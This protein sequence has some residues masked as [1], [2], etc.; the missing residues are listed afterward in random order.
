VLLF[1]HIIIFPADKLADKPHQVGLEAAE[2][3]HSRGEAGLR[4]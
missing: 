1:L 3:A 2:A 4:L